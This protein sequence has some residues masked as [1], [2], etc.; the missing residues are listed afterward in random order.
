MLKFEFRLEP[1][2]FADIRQLLRDSR[3]RNVA[4]SALF[5]ILFQI[6]PYI[7]MRLILASIAVTF[8]PLLRAKA[9]AIAV[10]RSSLDL[11]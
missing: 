11:Q 6:S 8:K 4:V 3:S 7:H 1:P 9:T 10:W 2:A 5:I